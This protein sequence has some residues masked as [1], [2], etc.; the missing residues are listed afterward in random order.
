[1]TERAALSVPLPWHQPTLQDWLARQQQGRLPHALLV[2]GPAGSGKRRLVAA[3]AQSLLCSAGTG[4]ACGECQGCHLAVAGTHPD[5]HWLQ[6]EEGKRQVRID[7]IRELVEFAA[8]TAQFGGYRVAVVEP[9]EAMNRNAQNALLK[10]LEEPGDRTL[11]MLVSDQPSLLLPTIRSRCQQVT[12]ARPEPAQA[13][14][15]LGERIGDEVR[16]RALLGAAGG[17]PLR[18]LSLDGANW[19]ADRTR[20]LGHCLALLEGRASASTVAAQLSE[21]DLPE[22]LQALA[23]WWQQAAS[24]TA[25]RAEQA[26]PELLPLYRR[27]RSRCQRLRLL[28]GARRALSFRRALLAGSNP[29]SE[30][31]LEQL[32]LYLAGVDDIHP[33]F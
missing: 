21:Y 28:D 5:F 12:V 9:A 4:P 32:M 19:F 29:N 16:A 2:S 8:R 20:L 7:Q 18:A 1:M 10:T 15:W 11:L 14:A 17:A 22:L 27:L 33:A 3:M 24:M 25:G 26:D 6:P 30:L 13:Q 31:L 23:L